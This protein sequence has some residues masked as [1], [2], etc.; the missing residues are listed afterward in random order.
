MS[1]ETL[2]R[3][4]AVRLEEARAQGLTKGWKL[5][6]EVY[7]GSKT[8][9]EFVCA[10]GH[11]IS[12]I[13]Q[14][15]N[16]N[17]CSVCSGVSPELAATNFYTTVREKGGY[18]APNS[19]IGSNKQVEITCEYGHKW[20]TTPSIIKFGSWCRECGGRTKEAAARKYNE[21]L[22]KR[23]ALAADP[24]V[25]SKDPVRIL[26]KEGHIWTTIPSIVNTDC[27]WCSSCA[28][29]SPVLAAEL[30][31]A[32]VKERG[33]IA[34]DKYINSETKLSIQCKKGH[35][36]LGRPDHIKSG[37]WCRTCDESKGELL[38]AKTLTEL[39]LPFEKQ[40]RLPELPRCSYD[41]L[42]YYKGKH[43][44]IEFDGKQHFRQAPY[45]TLEE[46]QSG[47]NRDIEK[48]K[49]VIER[50]KLRMIRI[51]YRALE[52]NWDMKSLL[53]QALD[54]PDPLVYIDSEMYAWLTPH[55]SVQTSDATSH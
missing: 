11:K 32:K 55:I 9:I 31:Y 8:K 38:V 41:F 42:T 13:A 20:N 53:R 7:G 6:T 44:F 30:Y 23:G 54:L 27:H 49:L 15:I 40:R 29:R 52:L 33:G 37:R 19:Y 26:C 17:K 43:V 5:I 16:R 51:G 1:I 10:Q 35:I 28:Q 3:Q 18:V 48:T 47:Q 22:I 2:A 50:Y 39:N 24:Y 4:R 36:F 45:H 34:I 12:L 21:I 25:S 46:F 14:H